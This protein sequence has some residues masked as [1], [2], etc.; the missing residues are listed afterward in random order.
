[1]NDLVSIKEKDVKILS[2]SSE[3]FENRGYIPIKYTCDGINTNPPIDINNI[4]EDTKSLVLIVDDVDAPIRA[5]THWIIWNVSPGKK[6]KENSH[7]GMEGINDFRQHHYGGPCP[8]SGTHRY[9]FKVY[10]LDEMLFLKKDST[11][12]ELEKTMSSHII[13]FGE[14]IGIY[15][16]AL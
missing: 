9:H 12:Y 6:I 16:R 13:A 14:L 11:K 1:M 3:A 4:P 7:S 2:V 8:P 15:R 10:A 5:W